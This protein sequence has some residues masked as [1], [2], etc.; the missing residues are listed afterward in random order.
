MVRLAYVS[1]PPLYFDRDLVIFMTGVQQ[2]DPLGSL[3]FAL[4]IDP[5][6][7]AVSS[8]FSVWYLDDGTF[9]GPVN[10][11]VDDHRTLEQNLLFIGLQLN[12][13]KCEVTYLGAQSSQLH[14]N[15]ISAVR[16]VLPGIIESPD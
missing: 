11:V 1:P 9:A 10:R 13:S 8:E 15:A 5:V 2:G 14:T 7:R 4:T 3:A 6:M 16:R 12:N